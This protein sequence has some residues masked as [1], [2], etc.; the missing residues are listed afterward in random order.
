MGNTD[1]DLQ[2]SR[3]HE[4]NIFFAKT[5]LHDMRVPGLK[6]IAAATHYALFVNLPKNRIYCTL[7]GFWRQLPDKDEYLLFWD[8]A[9]RDVDDGFTMLVNQS[10]LRIRSIEWVDVIVSIQKLALSKGVFRVADV[11]GESAVLKMQAERIAKISGI[12]PK[13]KT[14]TSQFQAETWLN[15]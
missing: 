7:N 14:F 8:E 3:V 12:F 1:L 10:N 9:M 4:Q 2:T 13:R 5:S 15:A 11:L 6:K